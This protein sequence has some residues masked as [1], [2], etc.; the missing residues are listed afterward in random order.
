MSLLILLV[1]S[2]GRV[3]IGFTAAYAITKYGVEAFSDALRREMRPWGI[4]VSIMEPGAFQTEITEPLAREKQMRQGWHN[5]SDELKREY[6][7]EYLERGI[8]LFV[9]VTIKITRVVK[10][11]SE[12]C[13]GGGLIFD[14]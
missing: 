7:K 4:K 6:G 3:S 12:I 10:L 2:T 13:I 8:R 1:L 9:H 11:P 5:L 14:T